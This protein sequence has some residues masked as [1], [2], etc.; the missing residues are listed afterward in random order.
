MSGGL[1]AA[2]VDEG[3]AGRGTAAGAPAPAWTPSLAWTWCAKEWR[4]QRAF[5][6][7]YVGLTLVAVAAVATAVEGG[8]WRVAQE[9]G[10]DEEARAVVVLCFAAACAFGAT[11]AAANAV[12]GEVVGSHDFLW[13]RLPG[14]L[15]A[16]F[17]GK[18]L[19]L[20]LL[21]PGLVLV[22]LIAGQGCVLALGQEPVRLSV[23]CFEAERFGKWPALA[24][25]LVPAVLAVASWLPGARQAVAATMVVAGAIAV[26]V[27]GCLRAS[28]ELAWSID[29]PFLVPWL[30]GLAGATAWV[31]CVRGRRGGGPWRSARL[32]G[33]VAVAG[34]LPLVLWFASWLDAYWR[35]DLRNLDSVE[36]RGVTGD[37]RYL[38]IEG[39][40]HPRWPAVAAR[41]DLATGE[42]VQISAPGEI[43]TSWFDGNG[44]EQHALVREGWCSVVGGRGMRAVDL[45]TLAT[46]PLSNGMQD[47]TSIPPALR[48][49]FDRLR[50]TC[51]TLRQAGD[52]PAWFEG[53]T[54]CLAQADGSV[55]R[56]A[57]PKDCGNGVA[58]G[59]GFARYCRDQQHRYYDF[60]RRAWVQPPDGGEETGHVAVRGL[61]L[62]R[63]KWLSRELVTTWRRFDPS[64]SA[65]TPIAALPADAQ[66]VGLLDDDFALFT[67][68]VVGRGLIA[69]APAH[70]EAV[71][72]EMPGDAQDRRTGWLPQSV[73]ASPFIASRDARSPYGLRDPDRRML[74]YLHYP[75]HTRCAVLAVDPRTR[76]AAIL[77]DAQLLTTILAFEPGGT[78]LCGE[79]YNRIVRYTPDGTRTL[80]YPK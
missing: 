10:F 18:L 6:L 61:W 60:T 76:K 53:D 68:R 77:L 35:P 58:A 9:V 17:A 52:L 27:R 16:A 28:P 46:H 13:R 14:G 63:P 33:M 22:G 43:V 1:E 78:I 29:A 39:K 55:E 24:S 74:L 2:T 62:L 71:P 44:L 38:L 8:W 5:L 40:A 19:F 41:V 21:L 12:R 31:S 67:E 11:F 30:V 57:L 15:Q 59:H 26:A 73:N 56:E 45:Q 3:A 34:A 50:R 4:A 32:G 37:G 25:T 65:V 20:L 42:A 80:V 47:A 48:A 49:R 64:A 70:D 72:I 36:S 51:A 79:D 75:G 66:Y 23:L 69:Y 7:G 54:L